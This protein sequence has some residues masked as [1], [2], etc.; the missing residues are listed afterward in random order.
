MAFS[1][2]F[3][4]LNKTE[5]NLIRVS[6]VAII[7]CLIALGVYDFDSD[8]SLLSRNRLGF[9]SDVRNDIRHKKQGKLFWKNAKRN[10]NIRAGDKIFTGDKSTAE[11]R[12]RDTT[13][14]RISE[15]SLVEF[16]DY[17]N[18][19]LPDFAMGT[20]KLAV[21]GKVKVM[22]NGKVA[23]LDGGSGENAEVQLTVDKNKNVQVK[24]VKGTA[25]LK[26]SN[27]VIQL[28][29][30]VVASISRE[31]MASLDAFNENTAAAP[32]ESKPT[33]S[34]PRVYKAPTAPKTI[35][36]AVGLYDIYE[37][38][39]D[40]LRRRDPQPDRVHAD[41]ALDFEG[42]DTSKPITIQHAASSDFASAQAHPNFTASSH[43]TTVHVGANFWRYT[44]DNQTWS[45]TQQFEV[46]PGVLANSRPK[47]T[48]NNPVALVPKKQA[49]AKFK[50]ESNI[51]ANGYIA[52][53]SSDSN[54]TAGKTST[55]WFYQSKITIPF[56]KT[57]T[58]YSRFRVV[59]KNLRLGEWSE[60]LATEVVELPPL[61][62]PRFLTNV[63]EVMAEEDVNLEWKK[64]KGATA[65]ILRVFD[66]EKKPLESIETSAR[67][68]NWKT[69]RPGIYFAQVQATDDYGRF[70]DPSQF[71]EIKV[72][73]P[74]I[75]LSGDP[76]KPKT[77]KP[78]SLDPDMTASFL[79]PGV[80]WNRGITKSNAMVMSNYY[81]FQSAAQKN[82]V[83]PA[84][85][86]GVMV[87]ALMWLKNHGV[88][89]I[90]HKN[91]AS[92]DINGQST[93]FYIAEM[94]YRYRLHGGMDFFRQFQSSLYLGYHMYRNSDTRFFVEKYDL[95]K[96]GM[97][98]DIPVFKRWVIGGEMGLG[99]QSSAQ[100]LEAAL[101]VDYFFRR[102]WSMGAG[103]KVFILEME[104]LSQF[105]TFPTYREGFTTSHLN[106][107]YFF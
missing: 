8:E 86:P 43:L 58:F 85:S 4:G 46:I 87:S 15:N 26:L 51:D 13:T 39:G 28:K 54:F 35:E 96:G 77:R 7:L 59:D 17:R 104:G 72:Q 60:T 95:V 24:S 88:Q 57:G 84:T 52:E 12:L 16:K 48:T 98:I 73:A 103:Y 22:I 34:A 44:D 92:S 6:A 80:G 81:T 14:F 27:K 33:A 53:Y 90:L 10:E 82:N 21:K 67:N 25:A 71:A 107:K 18:Q 75:R 9:I 64:S 31:E 100:L 5:K 20:F 97:S 101:G 11:V 19:N 1:K 91:L 65:Y 61:R 66:A 47:V 68:L 50:V 56:H 30:D 89:G 105:P 99:W 78:T 79:L 83:G 76:K 62:T 32:V 55:Y 38:D 42:V 106:M 40:R 3:A 29:E 63:F 23:E 36:Y 69:K 94:R 49:R 74:V 102:N 45:P 70:S 93:D 41:V 37:K 2:F